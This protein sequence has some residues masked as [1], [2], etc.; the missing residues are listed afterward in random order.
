MTYSSH[1]EVPIR[2][3][4]SK[5]IVGLLYLVFNASHKNNVLPVVLPALASVK[6]SGGTSAQNGVQ[7]RTVVMTSNLR[8]PSPD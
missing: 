4:C 6:Y 1:S 2:F 3:P 8:A 5:N 7:E